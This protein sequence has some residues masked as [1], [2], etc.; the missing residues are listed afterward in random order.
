[1]VNREILL[2]SFYLDLNVYGL[3]CL[4][5][6]RYPDVKYQVLSLECRLLTFNFLLL[7]ELVTSDKSV[8]FI[9]HDFCLNN[10]KKRRY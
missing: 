7:R 1:M 2:E 10:L 4:I 5:A 8:L 9:R 3:K 6:L